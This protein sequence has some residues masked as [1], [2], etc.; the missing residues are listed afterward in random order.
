MKRAQEL[1]GKGRTCCSCCSLRS[2]WYW[3]CFS[4]AARR[5]DPA[6]LTPACAGA[7]GGGWLG[8]Y[9]SGGGAG[10]ERDCARCCSNC[11]CCSS[12]WYWRCFSSCARRRSSDDGSEGSA[13][14][15][16]A[17]TWAGAAGVREGCAAASGCCCRWDTDQTP[18]EVKPHRPRNT[19]AQP[20]APPHL[21]LQQ[22]SGILLLLEPRQLPAVGVG[23]ARRRGVR[24]RDGRAAARG[25]NFQ[26][27]L[28]E[29]GSRRRVPSRLVA[30]TEISASR[31][32]A[33]GRVGAVRATGGSQ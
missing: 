17:G 27:R 15:A 33:R 10:R 12:V 19:H 2:A 26:R 20:R 4:T 1:G 16:T 7:W 25:R 21:L 11:C 13:D 28:W 29:R 14:E 31:C 6:S 30:A 24:V 8:T 32:L 22:L 3:R 23:G 9:W 5:F 18:S